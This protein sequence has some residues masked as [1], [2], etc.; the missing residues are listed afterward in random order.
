MPLTSRVILM[1]PS[2]LIQLAALVGALLASTVLQAGTIEVNSSGWNL[3]DDND[4]T[5]REAEIIASGRS[6][7]GKTCFRRN[8]RLRTTGVTWD[9]GISANCNRGFYDLPLETYCRNIDNA[10]NDCLWVVTSGA[11]WAVD[12]EIRFTNDVVTIS[13]AVGFG[14]WTGDTLN[15]RKPDASRIHLSGAAMVNS[16]NPDGVVVLSA[17]AILKDVEISQSPEHGVYGGTARGTKIEASYIH[18]NAADGIKFASA[19]ILGEQIS[20]RDNTIGST[21]A[22]RGNTIGD[23]GGSGVAIL[24]HDGH[25][26]F[27]HNN[28]LL[29]NSIAN[30]GYYGVYVA[31]SRGNEIGQPGLGN[32]IIDHPDYPAVTL[33][34]TNADANVVR[35]NSIGGNPAGANKI[36]ISL[37]AGADGNQL[38]GATLAEG[39]DIINSTSEGIKVRDADNNVIEGNYIG[40][41]KSGVTNGNGHDGIFVHQ[42]ALNTRINHNV[43]VA[44][45]KAGTP[46]F[47]WGIHLFDAGSTGNDIYGNRIGITANDTAAGNALGG[48]RLNG[49]SLNRIGKSGADGNIIAGHANGPGILVEGNTASVEIQRNRIGVKSDGSAAA[50]LGGIV[51]RG[52]VNAVLIGGLP[53]DGNVI[54]GNTQDGVWIDGDSTDGVVVRGNFIGTNATGTAALPNGRNGILVSAGDSSQVRDNLIGGNSN[55]GIKLESGANGHDIRNNT[56]GLSATLGSTL[57]NGASGIAILDSANNQVGTNGVNYV[58]ASGGSGIHVSGATASANTIANNL[59]GTISVVVNSGN[60]GSG[61]HLLNGA[62]G[63]TLRDNVI[64]GNG[65]AGIDLLNA[66]NNILAGNEIG[67]ANAAFIRSNPR[68]IRIYGGSSGNTVGGPAAADRNL[69]V[70]ATNY[71]I[72]IF[73]ADSD[74]NVL[75][76]NRIGVFD[77]QSE[78]GNGGTGGFGGVLIQEGASSNIL[79]GNQISNNSPTGVR[80]RNLG[81]LTLDN[82]LYDNTISFN[83]LEGILIEDG[84]IDNIIGA[85]GDGNEVFGN[86]ADGIGIRAGTGHRI[87]GNDIFSNDE[88]EIDLG[89]DSAT[90]N[91]AGDADTGINDLQNHPVIA[92]THTNIAQNQTQI[93]VSLDSLA[94]RDYRVTVYGDSD[95]EQ[96][97]RGSGVALLTLNLQ[98]DANGMG[99]GT[100][101]GSAIHA[102]RL[103]ASARDMVNGNS[104]E[105]GPCAA[106]IVRLFE[107]GFEEPFRH[108]SGDVMP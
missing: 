43:I 92:S 108:R 37:E 69:I 56:I 65:V 46:G 85:P 39:N 60:A 107:D 17:N 47:G 29:A 7:L 97:G 2:R 72:G 42:G 28:K 51:L 49:S 26:G 11:G 8:E 76:G 22:S 53:A 84:S 98:T 6:D 23:N 1:C 106:N 78:G 10:H 21:N 93:T 15:G 70:A 44:N 66:D 73:N 95:C 13:P 30:N 9:L 101:L 5:L 27:A 40:R 77:D 81:T 33:E 100:W 34:G 45:G 96:N 88:D 58:A 52:S 32:S 68:G 80:I 54:S 75:Q 89:T 59:V 16:A 104:S 61:I 35:G 4:L 90:A 103:S 57:G 19:L 83:T 102:P 12:D 82:Q 91:D 63:N 79:R 14:L 64:L 20:P 67:G 99:Q 71:G 94:Q 18:H 105:I 62:H 31:N 50:N 48:I 86:G 74:G 25:T 55:D 3:D 41:R 36:G 24:G 87:E 38:G